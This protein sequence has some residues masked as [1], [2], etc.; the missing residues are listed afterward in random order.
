VSKKRRQPASDRSAPPKESARDAKPAPAVTADFAREAKRAE[1]AVGGTPSR[2]WPA[3]LW[4]N[5]K[6][7]SGAAGDAS[8]LW[9]R[10]FVLR[11]VGL[12]FVSAFLGIIVEGQALAGPNGIS[13]VALY[14]KHLRSVVPAFFSGFVSAPSLFWLDASAGAIAAVAWLGFASAVALVVNL[15]PRLTLFVCWAC[16]LSFVATWAEFTPSQQ[17]GLLLEAALLSMAFAPPGIRPGL[18]AA[19]PPRPLA[20]FM[21]RWL[22]L[23]VMLLSGLVK[24]LSEGPAWRNWTAMDVMYETSPSP[25]VAGY[26]VHQLPHAYHVFE[27]WFTYAAELLAPL[28]ALFGGRRGRWVAFG[29]WTML[30]AG[31]QLTTNFGWL[32]TA[33]FAFGLLLLD[34]Q[35]LASAARRLRWPA[36]RAFFAARVAPH[37]SGGI[38]AWQRHGL[39]A[40]L[41]LHFALTLYYFADACSGPFEN[42][43]API[44]LFEGFR[45]ANGYKLYAHFAQAHFQID[46]EGSNDGGRTWRTYPLRHL[47]Q[48]PESRPEFTAPYFPRFDHTLHA[49]SLQEAKPSVIAPTAA[50]LLAQNPQV[51]ALFERDPFTDRPPTVIRMRRYRFT[52]TDPAT[53]GRTGRYWVKESAGDYQPAMYIDEKGAI[54][55]FDLG[56][57]DAAFRAGNH[58]AAYAEYERQYRQ[59]HLE[60]GFRLADMMA[61]GL[62]V[63]VQPERV[64]ALFSELAERGEV[65]GMQNVAV[66]YEHGIGVAPDMAKACE[67]YRRA[68]ELGHFAS[69]H[70]LGRLAAEDRLTPRHD[71]LALA[72][73]AIAASRAAD[74]EASLA[75]VRANHPALVAK[76]KA[77]MSPRELAEAKALAAA[78]RAALP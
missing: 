40:A 48:R 68:A 30:Q 56:P 71:A 26:W 50:H 78:R 60:A 77:R 70:T 1:G 47:P 64:F 45:S 17:D 66:C 21:M 23:R 13:P 9:P 20:V 7:F 32:N 74:D 59:G 4:R 65:K 36:L 61:R 19:H 5:T 24:I 73:L 18:G 53:L 41:G 58:G 39:R 67:F 44:R 54:A 11:G 27:I 72:A 6:E 52:F 42:R 55:Q 63:P 3:R 43:P 49:A 14:L 38:S 46:L 57:A 35:M 34:D 76:L 10:W 69:L 25:T 31:I 51:L 62:G 29:L 2:S 75:F 37:A 8:L 16:F 15:W 22:L 12:I 28:L 33:A